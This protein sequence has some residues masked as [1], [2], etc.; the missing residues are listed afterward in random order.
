MLAAEIRSMQKLPYIVLDFDST[1][2]QVEALEVLADLSLTGHPDYDARKAEIMQV[3]AL[4]ANGN[5]SLE[6]SLRRRIELLEAHRD[7]LPILVDRL[8]GKV[9]LSI[10]RNREFFRQYQDRVYLISNSFR[11]L[12]VPVV[13]DYFIKEDHVLGNE[14]VTDESGRIV[15]VDEANPLTKSNGKAEVLASLQLSGRVLVV[16]DAYMDYQ[17]KAAGLAHQFF[18]FTENVFR[19]QVMAQAD[20][21]VKTFDEFLYVNHLPMSVSYPKSKIKAL[22]LENIHPNAERVF[23]G[24][25]YQVEIVS[26]A[27]DEEELIDRIQ[28]VSILCIRSKTTVTRRVVEAGNRLLV[29]GTF[30]I[31]TNQIDLDAC[32]EKGVIVFNAP[33]SNTRSVVELAI[34]ELILL[35]RKIPQ[36]NAGMHRGEWN[37]S[38]KNSVEVRGK[39]L[40]IIGYGNIGSQLSVLAEALGMQ[41]YYFDLVEK[42]ALGNATKVESLEALLRE[43]D[44]LSIHVDGRQENA[45]FIGKDELAMMKRGA[46]LLNLSRGFVVDLAALEDAIESGHLAGAALDV[47]PE[48]PKSNE[49]EY[50]SGLRRFDNVILTP[51]IGGSTEEAQFNIAQYVPARV[52]AYINTGSTFGG[53]NF[54]NVQLPDQKQVHRLIHIHKNVPGILAKINQ[55]LA[56]HEVNIAGQ[57]LKTNESIGYVITDINREYDDA[58]IT[59][60]KKI[61]DTIKF[62]VLY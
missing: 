25:G 18:A 1:F 3:T 15:G 5:L 32:A 20:L 6:S 50:V 28:G 16:G 52:L 11:E 12:I 4:G 45:Y 40:G 58:L 10:A 59:D 47:Y 8:K 14:F 49:E 54:P 37:K 36:M 22:I 39:K 31:G 62:R 34:G 46:I 2:L 38:A 9:S 43:V 30:S 23:R 42:L 56:H 60:L 44:F 26:S 13:A 24:E 51:H 35:A 55:V 21:V 17:M 7:H 19:D 53:V 57:Y 29:V 33:Y 48:E 27:L 61:P 41:V